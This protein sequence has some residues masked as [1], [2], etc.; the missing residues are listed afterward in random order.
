MSTKQ[1]ANVY[2]AQARNRELTKGQRQMVPL[3]S[4]FVFVGAAWT[5]GGRLIA[6]LIEAG[7]S[8][9]WQVILSAYTDLPG[10]VFNLPQLYFLGGTVEGFGRLLDPTSR[11]LEGE[12]IQSGFV[13][14]DYLNFQDAFTTLNPY[15]NITEFNIGGCLIPKSLVTDPKS[16]D[17]LAD[18]IRYITADGGIFAGVSADVS[19]APPYSKLGSSRVTQVC[20]SGVLRNHH[21]HT[22]TTPYGR[23][24]MATNVASQKRA[25]TPGGS[26]YL[27]E[28]DVNQPNWQFT[29]YGPNY[30]RLPLINKYDP[31][32]TLWAPTTVGSEGWAVDFDG[33]LCKKN[34]WF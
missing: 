16:T 23:T 30:P 5:V 26:A 11:A 2:Q 7:A 24:S 20:L 14:K 3:T 10:N 29:F 19:K 25:L 17:S 6:T 13:P 4:V 27:N 1:K 28:A 8:V 34:G 33:R 22:Q 32:G 21:T 9:Y 15:Q 31:A 12:G 18:A